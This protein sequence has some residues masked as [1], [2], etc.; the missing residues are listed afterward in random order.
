MDEKRYWIEKTEYRTANGEAI[1]EMFGNSDALA[2]GE[3]V[4]GPAEG[5]DDGIAADEIPEGFRM[6]SPEEWARIRE[7]DEDGEWMGGE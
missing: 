3:M 1:Y 4:A 5:N 2:G 6:V 7:E